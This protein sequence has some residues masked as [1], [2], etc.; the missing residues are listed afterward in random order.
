MDKKTLQKIKDELLARKKQIMDDL[1]NV[2]H[3]TKNK[4]GNEAI[5]P[6]FG[7]KDEE[8]A[9]E[10]SEYSTHLATEKVLE[11]SLRDIN[12]ALDRIK[13]GDYGVCK[14]CG[15][16]IGEKRLLARPTAS[17]CVSCKNK[18]QQGS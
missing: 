12:N 7:D 1:E 18:L 10:V 11:S 5:F 3:Q 14:Y 17:A 9:M 2:A 4:K 6:K 15:Q 13:K 16:D 8:N